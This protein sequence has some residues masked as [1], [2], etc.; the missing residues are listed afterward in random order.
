MSVQRMWLFNCGWLSVEQ[1]LLSYREGFGSQRIIP[2]TATLVETD[3][4]YVLFDT[5]LN[6][7]AIADPESALQHKASA[8]VDFDEG[9]GILAHLE[10]V[11]LGPEDVRWLTNSHLHWDHTGGNTHVRPQ[12][13]L[14]QREELRFAQDPD[15]FVEAIFLASQFGVPEEHTVLDGDTL[16]TE[17]V[18][19][20]STRG[21]TPG[22]Q[23]LLV[24]L[25]S[26]R[27]MLCAGDAAYQQSNLDGPWPPGNAWSMPDA[28]RAL[29]RM[30]F[31]R[32]FSGAEIVLGHDEE[33]WDR[34]GER[35]RELR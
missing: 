28:Y 19:L 5:G 24:R 32:D 7:E 13:F 4:G 15:A 18:G 34:D 17:G 29:R 25:P 27:T 16:I 21:H 33:L 14:V 6:V 12:E 8:I 11:G 31:E 10:S 23:S 3:E 20:I 2:V 1:S 9:H 22:H 35:V 30:N 26:G